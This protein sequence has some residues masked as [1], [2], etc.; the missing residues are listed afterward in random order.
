[1][2]RQIIHGVPYF[3]DTLNRLFTWDAE[4]QPYPIGTYSP[5]TNTITY[6]DNHIAQL[7]QRLQTWR[8][9]QHARLRKPVAASATSGGDSGGK[10]NGQAN[11]EDEI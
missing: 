8:T 11:S 10:A 1:M 7:S 6:T 3:T 2:Q 4:A 9:N 5:T